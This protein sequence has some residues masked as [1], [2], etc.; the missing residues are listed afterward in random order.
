MSWPSGP[1]QD[2]ETG[3]G[4]MVT[5]CGATKG[6]I[7]YIGISYLTKTTAAKLGTASLA[8]KAGKFTQPTSKT[9]DAALATFS[10]STPANGAQPLINTSAAKGYPIINYEYAVVKKAQPSAAVASALKAFLKWTLTTGAGPTFLSAVGF[11]PLPS[12]VQTIAENQ[13]ASISG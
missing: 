9:I 12:N 13:I 8:N 10:G 1:A 5:G 6:C 11:E 3:S 7:A 2:A 4:G